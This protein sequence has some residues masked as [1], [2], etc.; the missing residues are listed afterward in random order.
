MNTCNV[1][2]TNDYNNKIIIV[3]DPTGTD[4]K[5]KYSMTCSKQYGKLKRRIRRP[6][7][8]RVYWEDLLWKP[9][10]KEQ[11]EP[12]K[13]K[14]DLEGDVSGCNMKNFLL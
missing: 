11:E 12:N 14:E 8:G 4:I 9:R 2:R 3:S 1:L 13:Q 10:L 6:T 7:L 5:N